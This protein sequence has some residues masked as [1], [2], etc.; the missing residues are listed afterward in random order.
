MLNASR[1]YLRTVWWTAFFPGAA[2]LSLYSVSTCWTT[3]CARLSTPKYGIDFC[4][5]SGLSS[6][7]PTLTV[8]KWRN[9]NAG[10]YQQVEMNR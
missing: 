9:Y 1:A 5:N 8:C 6:S 7:A 2:I 3:V 10:D 4:K